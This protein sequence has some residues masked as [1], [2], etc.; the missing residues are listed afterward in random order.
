MAGTQNIP[1]K[2]L[3]AED[4][5]DDIGFFFHYL[6]DRSD[7]HLL[8][9]VENGEE[10]VEYLQ[11]AHNGAFPD[12]IILDQNMPKCNGLQ[13]LAIIKNNA[14]FENI[15][16]FVYSTYTDAYLVKQ[17]LQLGARSVLEKPVS[18]EGYHKMIDN[19]LELI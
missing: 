17:S 14:Q 3:L 12:L 19:I 8:P 2:V 10:V 16:V 1:K 5:P 11:K 15:P 4:D 6:G 9:P 7:L 13:T 18:V